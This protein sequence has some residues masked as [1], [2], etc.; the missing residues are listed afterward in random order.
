MESLS[1]SL[2]HFIQ[3]LETLPPLLSTLDNAIVKIMRYRYQES[4]NEAVTTAAV[5]IIKINLTSPPHS[6]A[7]YGTHTV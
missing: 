7:T 2:N 4:N 1:I 5:T 6:T 3:T